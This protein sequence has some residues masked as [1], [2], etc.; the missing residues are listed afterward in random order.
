MLL[1]AKELGIRILQRVCMKR[2]RSFFSDSTAESHSLP[3]T[4]Y[5]LCCHQVRQTVYSVD[6]WRIV[7]FAA[8][9]FSLQL[10]SR[11]QERKQKDY[12]VKGNPKLTCRAKQYRGKG[13]DFFLTAYQEGKT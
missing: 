8:E 7:L 4:I 13:C 6:S 1:R 2:S 10:G 5:I 3:H 9:S 12:S 11:K